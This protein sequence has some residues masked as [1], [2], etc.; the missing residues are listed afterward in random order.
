[1]TDALLAIL[2]F[3]GVLWLSRW[4]RDRS[5]HHRELWAIDALARLIRWVLIMAL[6]WTC[7]RLLMNSFLANL[8]SL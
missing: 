7:V 8:V 4:S 6:C 2:I 1:M 3:W 5:A